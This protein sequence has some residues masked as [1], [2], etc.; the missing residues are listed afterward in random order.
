MN[1]LCIVGMILNLVICL[2]VIRE[3]NCDLL[4]KLTKLGNSLCIIL[5]SSF[6]VLYALHW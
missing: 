3:I 4:S 6:L 5:N 2:L 1:D